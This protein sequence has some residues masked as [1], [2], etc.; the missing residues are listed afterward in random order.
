MP[1]KTDSS[2]EERFNFSLPFFLHGRNTK[3]K[4]FV[5]FITKGGGGGRQKTLTSTS[6][7]A[8]NWVCMEV[9]RWLI[10]GLKDQVFRSCF[11]YPWYFIISLV[12]CSRGESQ[13]SESMHPEV[14]CPLCLAG[15]RT[16]IAFV[17]VSHLAVCSKSGTASLSVG[18]FTCA[19]LVTASEVP[20]YD[21]SHSGCSGAWPV[22]GK[23]GDLP[24]CWFR[25]QEGREGKYTAVTKCYL[26]PIGALGKE[27]KSWHWDCRV[28]RNTK[29]NNSPSGKGRNKCRKAHGRLLK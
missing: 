6:H 7:S 21:V 15:G 28:R 10:T 5:A 20:R 8:A 4:N 11:R 12:P 17:L 18:D 2:L 13:A 26:Y 27:P 25:G 16:L 14:T 24:P 9:E 19:P 29:G 1:R 22:S 3:S 23:R